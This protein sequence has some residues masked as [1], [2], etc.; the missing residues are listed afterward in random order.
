MGVHNRI[1]EDKYNRI[2]KMLH[3]PADDERVM[4]IF[5]IGKSTC[6]NIRR[7]ANYS[8]YCERVF[9]FHGNPKGQKVV[10]RAH[11]PTHPNYGFIYANEPKKEYTAE[12]L[13]EKQMNKM[14]SLECLIKVYFEALRKTIKLLSV[15]LVLVA[16]GVLCLGIWLII[17]GKA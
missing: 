1:T 10:K 5:E 9:R 16:I 8:E 4:G 6:Q 15:A 7:T 11:R 3:T 12:E 13:H 17:G 14:E 2:K